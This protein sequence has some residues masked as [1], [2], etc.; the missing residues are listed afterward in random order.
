MFVRT[1]RLPRPAAERD[2]ESESEYE[3]KFLSGRLA[4]IE[5]DRLLEVVD[6]TRKELPPAEL[7]GAVLGF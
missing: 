1:A 2:Q 7:S 4:F 6:E 3:A 5:R